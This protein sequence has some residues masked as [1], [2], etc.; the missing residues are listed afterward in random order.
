MQVA[1]I[2]R[3]TIGLGNENQTGRGLW[4]RKL[5]RPASIVAM[6]KVS[7]F[8]RDGF[9]EAPLRGQNIGRISKLAMRWEGG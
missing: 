1:S 2:A 8:Q 7:S 3:N 9:G 5:R 4:E 6:R